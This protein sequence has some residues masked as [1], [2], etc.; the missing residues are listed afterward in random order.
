MVAQLWR[1]GE[2]KES[3]RRKQRLGREEE[4]TDSSDKWAHCHVVSTLTKPATKTTGW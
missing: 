1:F 4:M 2:R 3:K